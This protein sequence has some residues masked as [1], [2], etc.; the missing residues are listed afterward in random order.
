M[1]ALIDCNNFYVSCEKAFK[2]Q[3]RHKPL[4]VLSNNDGCVIARSNDTK[5]YIPMGAPI[6]KYRE[7]IER[8][9]VTVLSTNFSLYGNM[10]Q[11]VQNILHEMIPAV[12]DYSIDEFF[13]DL[14]NLRDIDY[15]QFGVQVHHNV[16][17]HT[18]LPTSIGIAPTKVLAKLANHYA[19]KNRKKYKNVYVIDS[20]DKR[21]ELLKTCRTQNIWGINQ[22]IVK[23]LQAVGIN[24]AYELSRL[25]DVVIK[26]LFS[27]MELR[28]K[29]EL[30]GQ[31]LLS[32][33]D[34]EVRKKTITVTRSFARNITS[35]QQL[36]ERISTFTTNCAKKLRQQNDYCQEL[37]VFVHTNA[38]R[39]DLPQHSKNIVLKLTEPSNNGKVLTEYALAGLAKIYQP[40]FQ[41][42]KAGIIATNFVHQEGTTEDL[43][44]QE[45]YYKEEK[46]H[47][48]IDEI[49][50]NQRKIL[51]AQQNTQQWIM[52][53]DNLSPRYT[54]NWNDLLTV[55]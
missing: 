15:Y 23:R 26:R 9:N 51:F 16:L 1:Y 18:Q 29:Y 47:K 14:K 37:L 53:Q 7:L 35:L 8:H 4:V 6:F 44:A 32:L 40:N 11:R 12:E 31:E 20:N 41:Y 54:T 42:K 30:L 43:F 55:Q 46:L 27:V 34:N 33:E 22:R 5:T 19:K 3:L 24:T 50:T 52:A 21:D 48:A 36:E 39:Q 45:N 38:Y 10:S 25:D 2:P 49:N 17:M 13:L 28:L